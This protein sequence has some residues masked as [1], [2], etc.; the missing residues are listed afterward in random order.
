MVSIL[1]FG[2]SSAFLVMTLILAE[3]ASLR[4]NHGFLAN[5][6]FLFFIR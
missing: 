4:S 1:H 5:G 2:G 6:F 3:V